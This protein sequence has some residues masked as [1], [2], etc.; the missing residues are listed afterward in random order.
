MNRWK[1]F[2]IASNVFFVFTLKNILFRSLQQRRD[3]EGERERK[4]R[5]VRGQQAQ[6]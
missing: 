6:G 4:C 3:G 2:C 1:C 5:S